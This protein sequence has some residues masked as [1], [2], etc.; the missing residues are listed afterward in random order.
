[1]GTVR[2]DIEAVRAFRDQV[3]APLI[4]QLT[5]LQ[6][7]LAAMKR[8]TLGGFLPDKPSQST[9]FVDAAEIEQHHEERRLD[10]VRRLDPLIDALRAEQLGDTE[11]LHE[12]IMNEQLAI[13]N[14]AKLANED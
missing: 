7:T 14:A 1:M 9:G 2:V 13:A 11:A 5:S 6:A 8:P 4:G 10:F 3:V 12:Y